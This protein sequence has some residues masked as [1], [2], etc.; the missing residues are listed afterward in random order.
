MR[1]VSD[2]I[3]KGEIL[4][5]LDRA[6][7]LAVYGKLKPFATGYEITQALESWEDTSTHVVGELGGGGGDAAFGVG[8]RN[9]LARPWASGSAPRTNAAENRSLSGSITWSGRVLGFTREGEVAAGA[10]EL[11]IR[12]DTLDGT[13]RLTAL[14]S[15]PGGQPPGAAGTGTPLGEGNLTY[16]VVV[17]GNSFVAHGDDAGR[18]TGALFG[19]FHAGMGGVIERDGLVAGF[20]GNDGRHAVPV[21]SLTGRDRL[22]YRGVTPTMTRTN[23]PAHL[24]SGSHAAGH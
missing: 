8:L 18:V 10:A 17:R 23:G 9:G 21:R 20:G 24:S 2:S 22:A 11:T 4:Y 7:L 16:R 5:P 1:P 3:R 15:W 13:L 14:E 6:A 12:L 19:E